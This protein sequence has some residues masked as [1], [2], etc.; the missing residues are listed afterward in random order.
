[1]S[2]V[3]EAWEWWLLA[4]MVLLALEMLGLAFVALAIGLSCVAGAVTAWAGGSLT[5]QIGSTVLAAMILTPVLVRLFRQRRPSDDSI[6]LA[7]E[8]DS[9]GQVYTLESQQGR[10]GIRIKGDFFPV[11]N[12]QGEVLVAGQRVIVQGFSGIT[13]LVTDALVTDATSTLTHKD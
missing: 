2:W 8:A 7:G 5:L 1:M 12:T 9:T 13:A 10:L 4:G 6:V 11:E 3:I